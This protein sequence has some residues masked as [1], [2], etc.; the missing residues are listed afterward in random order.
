[1]Y[2]CL[3]LSIQ[4]GMHGLWL[5][6]QNSREFRIFRTGLAQVCQRSRAEYARPRQSAG[7]LC[8][9]PRG[10]NDRMRIGIMLRH[11]PQHPGGVV[12]FTNEL[13]PELFRISSGHEFVLFFQRRPPPGVL[14]TTESVRHVVLPVPSRLLWDQVAVPVAQGGGHRRPVQS[15]V[16]DTI[17]AGCRTAWACHGLDWYV[18]PWAS[19]PVDRLSHR[20]L[21]P[22]YARKA[23]AIIAVSETVRDHALQYLDLPPDKLHVVYSGVH[24]RFRT[25]GTLEARRAL[26]KRLN[27][28]DRF[29]LFVGALYPPKNFTRLIQAYG[30]VG[31]SRGY[32]L[33]IAGGTDRFLA[34]HEVRLGRKLGLRNWVHEHGW[35]AHEELPTLYSLATGLLLPSLYEAC[36]LPIIEAM[37][38]GCPIVTSNRYGTAELAGDVAVTVDPESLESIANGIARLLDNDELRGVLAARGR[39]RAASMTWES[40]ARKT[41]SDSSRCSSHRA[42][43]ASDRRC[44]LSDVSFTLRISPRRTLEVMAVLIGALVAAS[45]AA[46][47]AL[48][49]F[50]WPEGSLGHESV[51]M[52][53][54][55]AEKNLPT[56]Y[57]SLALGLAAA[58]MFVVARVVAPIAAPRPNAVEGPRKHLRD[59]GARRELCASMKPSATRR[60]SIS[61]QR[62]LVIY[63]PVI[64]L[65]ALY[66]LPLLC[67]LDGRMRRLLMVAAVL[68]VGG[69]GGIESASQLYAG[70]AGK[71]TPLYVMLATLEE[72]LEMAGI[73][74][75]VY[76]LLDQLGKVRATPSSPGVADAQPK[77]NE[78]NLGQAYIS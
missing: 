28:P 71:A 15:E 41:L 1:M 48:A 77:P 19:R 47:G 17:A 22:Q 69:A 38:A 54:L 45:T 67:R 72:T 25:P 44:A 59:S 60:P 52:F 66:W 3:S 34:A 7:N 42:G 4:K 26:Q 68:Y 5:R 56:L 55:D 50:R 74:L 62:S 32:H 30:A 57:Q 20:L 51:K 23:D 75:P 21:V 65:L 35:L 31:P 63:V 43:C 53:W 24:E 2:V 36:P 78:S 18:M 73:A 27:L 16:L 64:A 13:L 29:V 8:G 70:V 10:I 49:L 76:A 58:L 6:A 33:V 39:A 46:V 11:L 61:G 9:A 12:V 40:T 14:S 37:A